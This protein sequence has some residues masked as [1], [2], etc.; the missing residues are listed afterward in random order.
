[1]IEPF[2]KTK[3]CVVPPE[4]G[5]SSVATYSGLRTADCGQPLN[6]FT[7]SPND[8]I[9]Q[10]LNRPMTQSLNHPIT[11]S[12]NH[13]ITAIF[14]DVG[15]L[16]GTNGW[17]RVSRRKAAEQFKIDG[18]ELENRHELV[19]AAFEIGQLTLEDYLNRIVFYRP[20]DFTRQEFKDFMFAQS[21]P[22]PESLALFDRLARSKKYFLATLNNESLELNLERIARFG[23]RK[24]F[25]VFFSSC[26]LG[27]KK[28]DV[29]IYQLALKMTQRAP[30]ECLFI[31]DRPLNVECARTCGMNTIHCQDPA[32]LAEQLRD[33]SIEI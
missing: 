15:G 26:F 20:R 11:Q 16:L 23:L 24:Y 32:L 4:A 3:T 31:D 14:S 25:T 27:I 19:V 10:S 9:T 17:D 2:T 6:H 12:R 18:V 29:A 8:S 1:M 5:P 28:P 22:F 13:S 7:Q 33:V 30:E 21:Q